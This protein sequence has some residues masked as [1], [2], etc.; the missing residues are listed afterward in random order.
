MT[1]SEI[2]DW[3]YLDHSRK[4]NPAI[5]EGMKEVPFPETEEDHLAVF[6]AFLEC[7]P[8]PGETVFE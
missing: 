1:E 6:S 2:L 7:C 5:V 8:G 4:V 3:L